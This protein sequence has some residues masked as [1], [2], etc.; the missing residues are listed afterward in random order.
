MAE[1]A[2]PAGRAETWQEAHARR[3]IESN[4]EDGHIWNGVPTLLL[5][6]T[7]RSSGKPRL[8]PLIYGKDG[9]RYL[10]VASRGG[11]PDH[12][13]WYKNLVANP[14]V[15]LQVGAERFAARART[16]NAAEKPALWRVM[17][18]VW[19]GYDEY[20]AKTSREIPVVI[21]E[22]V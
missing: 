1:H 12:P 10:I 16:A 2:E 3:Y 5:T 14:E 21:L 15:Q 20:Q 7:G 11:A 17:T 8:T 22:R 18:Q 4:G 19:P 9:D 6:T 13:H